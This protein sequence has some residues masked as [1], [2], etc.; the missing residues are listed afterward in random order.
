MEIPLLKQNAINR[1]KYLFPK[2]IDVPERCEN[3]N[4]SKTFSGKL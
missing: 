1:M 4:K 2:T 3:N